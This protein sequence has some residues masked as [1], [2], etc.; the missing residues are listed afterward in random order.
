MRTKTGLSPKEYFSNIR[1]LWTI[2][3]IVSALLVPSIAEPQRAQPP[4]C[5]GG[6]LDAPILLE[7]FSDFQC[8]ACRSFYLDVVTPALRDYARAGKI[9]ILYSEYPLNG[10]QYSREAARY[11]VAAQNINRKLWLT[12]MDTLYRKQPLWTLD[13]NIDGA[14]ADVVSA[15]D[16]ARIKNKA[17]EPAIEEEVKRE[18]A[19]GDSKKI[20][21]TPTIFVTARDKT[22]RV[23]RVLPYKVWKDFFN[24][25]LK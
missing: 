23:D 1:E 11:S 21:S 24:D 2:L 4:N 18:V 9:C 15:Q 12:V 20:R 10:H 3:M 25:M 5:V 14:L 6:T 19:Y 8:P 7:V 17:A 22:Q 16:L 13:G